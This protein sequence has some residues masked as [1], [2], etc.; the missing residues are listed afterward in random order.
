MSG[1]KLIK[2]VDPRWFFRV[3]KQWEDGGS[4]FRTLNQND[5]SFRWITIPEMPWAIHCLLLIFP[6]SQKW[7]S[8]DITFR[9]EFHRFSLIGQSWWYSWP[10]VIMWWSQKQQIF[11]GGKMGRLGPLFPDTRNRHNENVKNALS[12]II[13]LVQIYYSTANELWVEM[14]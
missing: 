4:L 2:E 7:I 6:F 11:F 12:T 8:R 9:Y 5:S 13:Y 14:T 1:S 3:R 10:L